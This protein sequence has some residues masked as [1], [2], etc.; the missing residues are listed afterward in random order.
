MDK[1]TNSFIS[2]IYINVNEIVDQNKAAGQM[3]LARR[4]WKFVLKN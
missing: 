3:L 4:Y 1:M 2:D